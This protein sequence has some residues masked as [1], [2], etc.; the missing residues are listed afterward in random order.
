MIST[1]FIPGTALHLL[2]PVLAANPWPF[3]GVVFLDFDGVLHPEGGGADIEF[4]FMDNFCDS[5]R[6]VDPAG[7]LAIVVSSMWRFG[8]SLAELRSHF[9]ADIGRRIVGVTPDLAVPA[10]DDPLPDSDGQ[11]FEQVEGL[12]QREIELWMVLNVP[13][14]RLDCWLAIDDRASYFDRGCE[15]LFLVPDV[16]DEANDGGGLS[17]GQCALLKERLRTLLDASPCVSQDK[18]PTGP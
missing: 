3:D 4:M 18:S 17:E 16:Y 13:N 5:V 2:D 11:W 7:R 6:E 15:R 1:R 9:P 8:S 14:D 12:R 10:P